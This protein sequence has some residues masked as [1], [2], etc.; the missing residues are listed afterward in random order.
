M[1]QVLVC[2]CF[3][4]SSSL[5]YGATYYVAKTG[6]D[7]YS[8]SQAQSASRPKLTIAAGL[9]C[10]NNGDTLIIKNGT[11]EEF[12]NYNQ[13]PAGRGSWNSAT[14]IMSAPGETV[15]LQPKTGGKAGDAVWIYRSYIII[16]GLIIDAANVSYQGI[17]VNNGASYVRIREF[18]SQ[19]C[20]AR[21]LYRYSE[22]TVKFH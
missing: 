15:I 17:R 12:I 3:F 10:L 18:R 19:E 4:A 1:K 16:D 5:G 11:Y 6:N 9:A 21:Q 13:I 8:C 14:K 7:N 20:L 2:S 22:C